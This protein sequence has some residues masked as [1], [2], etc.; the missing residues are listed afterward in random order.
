[1]GGGGKSGYRLREEG[2]EMKGI[3]LQGTASDVGKSVLC[4]ALCRYFREEGFQVAP[5][6]AQN[7]ALNSFITAEGDEIGRAQGVQAEAAGVEATADMNPVLLK[8][9]GEHRAE[10]VVQGRRL[11]EMEAKEY[12]GLTQEMMLKPI[13]QS[14]KRLSQEFDVVVMEGAGSPAEVNLK[15]RDIANMRIAELANVPVILVADIDRGGVFASI[16]GTLELLDSEERRRIKGLIINKFRGDLELFRPGVRWLEERTGIP[17]LGVMPFRQMEVEPEDSL[18]LDS[19]TRQSAGEKVLDLA[20]IR[21]PRIANYTDFLPLSRVS[22]VSLRFVRTIRE[23]GE[24]DAVFLPGTDSVFPD[25]DWLWEQGWVDLLRDQVSQGTFLAGVGGG[26]PMMGR[27]LSCWDGRE[28]EGLGVVPVDFS[29]VSTP[30]TARIKGK[31]LPEAWGETIGVEG[32]VIHP[33]RAHYREGA[34]PLLQLEDGTWEGWVSPDKQIWGTHLHG[35]FDNPAFTKNWLNR[36]RRNK[37]WSEID[38]VF[39]SGYV[40]REEVYRELSVWARRH[41]DLGQISKMMGL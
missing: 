17:V 21:F 15:D 11:G 12:Q 24:P 23:L 30:K 20:V 32:Y 1:M 16:V 5:F 37:G 13:R 8:P 26:Y 41:L 19:L 31:V 36:I 4:T 28:R 39:P 3:M 25:L 10:V 2:K 35:L 27:R 7:M 9:K 18:A 6:K 34:F 29:S 33:G 22:G 38:D 40:Q 14:L